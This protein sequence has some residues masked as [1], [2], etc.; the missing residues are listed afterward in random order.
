MKGGILYMKNIRE[1]ETFDISPLHPI[2]ST[3][4]FNNRQMIDYIWIEKQMN[5]INTLTERQ[6]YIVRAYTIYGDKFIN[7]YL[8][9]TLSDG[10]IRNFIDD[11]FRNNENPFLYQHY[12]KTGSYDINDTYIKYIKEY[13]IKFIDEFKEIIYNSPRLTKKMRV[14]RGIRDG[15]FL[16]D[17]I[18]IND[19]S[20]QYYKNT[21][22]L[23]TSF[24][25]ESATNFTEND[26]CLLELNLD[27][28]VP[29]LFTAHISRRRNEYEI[30]IAPDTIM[31]L[32]KCKRKF[33]LNDPSYYDDIQTLFYPK[34]YN[35]PIMR[36]CEFNIIY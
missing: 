12:D 9:N 5:Y 32:V 8:R 23:S 13:I 26:C 3:F 28:D 16:M 10:Q 2:H 30:T 7:N 35:I 24:Y 6:K 19:D 22:F 15:T 29:C 25:L 11:A 4:V 14:F 20:N 34:K 1:L 33:V 17:G 18:E 36:M 21:E 31:K 27:T